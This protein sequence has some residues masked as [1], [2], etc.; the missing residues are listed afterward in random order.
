MHWCVGRLPRFFDLSVAV[1]N[2]WAQQVKNIILNVIC[3]Y[4]YGLLE[5][6]S[7]HALLM[8]FLNSHEYEFTC[9]YWICKALKI[10]SEFQNAE[11]GHH[12]RKKNTRQIPITSSL[13]MSLKHVLTFTISITFIIDGLHI[14]Y[15][16]RRS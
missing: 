3:D 11:T 7:G 15:C 6:S 5:S 13:Q 4:K 16:P 12:R 14:P 2:L 9:I 1:H 8:K 10:F